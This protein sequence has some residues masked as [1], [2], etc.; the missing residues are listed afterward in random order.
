MR[1]MILLSKEIDGFPGETT[2]SCLNSMR[3]FPGSVEIVG[4]TGALKVTVRRGGVLASRRKL[5]WMP[6]SPTNNRRE[7]SRKVT[8]APRKRGSMVI[9]ELSGIIPREFSIRNG[10]ARSKSR[11]WIFDRVFPAVNSASTAL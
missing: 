6:T 4:L 2:G 5:G 7:L 10:A 3:N 8:G 11:P 1:V 9:N